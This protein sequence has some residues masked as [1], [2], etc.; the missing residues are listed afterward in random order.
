MSRLEQIGIQALGVG[1]CFVWAFGLGL[2]FYFLIDKFLGGVRVSEEEEILGLNIAEHGATSSI[3]ELAN[4]MNELTLSGDFSSGKQVAIEEGTEIGDLARLFNNMIER[5]KAALN[6]SEEQKNRAQMMLKE[7]HFQEAKVREA[8]NELQET[9]RSADIRRSEFLKEVQEKLSVVTGGIDGMKSSMGSTSQVTQQM[10]GAFDLMSDT[11]QK[12]LGSLTEVYSHLDQMK[13]INTSATSTVSESKSSI[14]NLRKVTMEIEEMVE[15][16]NNIA[17][18]THVLSINSGI[19]AAKAGEAGAGFNVISQEVRKLSSE[20]AKV[21]E[22]IGGKLLDVRSRVAHVT[23]TMGKILDIM[24][25]V[26]SI[27]G[28]IIDLIGENK[29]LSESVSSESSETKRI[30]VNVSS[31]IQNVVNEADKLSEIGKNVR[32]ELDSLNN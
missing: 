30:V 8:Q 31:D 11:L 20:T 3:L 24:T 17:D 21:A 16:I 22:R 25:D 29:I 7:A 4:T 18:E 19:E 2:I 9:R 32:N 23:E 27:N 5:I 28:N 1:A 15:Y 6:E 10:T 12:M 13:D 14:E 26:R